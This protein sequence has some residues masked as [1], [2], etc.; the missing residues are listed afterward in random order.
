[1]VK[2]A[3]P[4]QTRANQAQC[5][6]QATRVPVSGDKLVLGI[7]EHVL[8]DP[9]AANLVAR[10]DTNAAGNYLFVADIVEFQRDGENWV[11]FT[12]N[13]PDTEVPVE[14][15]RQRARRKAGAE[16][17]KDVSVR[18]RMMLGDVTETYEFTLLKRNARDYQVR[19]GRSFLKDM[20]LVDVSKRFIQPRPR[21]DG[22]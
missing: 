5:K 22:A 8:L 17:T 13:L 21:P 9:P 14:V 3:C 10:I 15:E 18:L 11:R 6:A 19:L 16:E 4:T 1:M 7:R 2:A 20:A 12:I